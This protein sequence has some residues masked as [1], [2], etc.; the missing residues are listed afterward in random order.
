M[1]NGFFIEYKLIRCQKLNW[2]N[3]AGLHRIA[4]ERAKEEALKTFAT[5]NA[6]GELQ[7]WTGG[8]HDERV[9]FDRLNRERQ[10]LF[11][12]PHK[13]MRIR[14]MSVD[15]AGVEAWCAKSEF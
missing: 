1:D 8:L 15:Y 13:E 5:C 3:S 12:C 7:S 6:M 2:L 11:G 4:G 14:E 9:C 10:H